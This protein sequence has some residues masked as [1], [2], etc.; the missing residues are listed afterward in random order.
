MKTDIEIQNETE[1]WPIGK[2]AEKLGLLSDQ[3]ECYGKYKAKIAYDLVKNASPK[4]TSQLI[5]V[6]AISPTP[7][8][9]GKTTN[10]IGIVDALNRLGKKA[11]TALR[12]PSLGPTLGMKGGAAGGGYAQVVPMEDINLHFT[13]DF[14]A[15][16]YAN[17]LLSCLID[18]HI[19]YGNA[20]KID[21]RDIKFKRT[22]D[23]DDRSLREL[24]I[25]L[26]IDH[27]GQMSV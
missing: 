2:V 14:H 19:N 6:S 16:T 26:V 10:L 17:N 21:Y 12:E 11:I 13:G 22:F 8:G 23:L 5:L 15:I 25:G 1:F 3:I 18:N 20:L 4:P 9:V 27:Q 7:A 24:Y